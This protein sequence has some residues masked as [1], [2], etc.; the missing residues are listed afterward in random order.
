[1]SIRAILP[2][3]GAWKRLVVHAGES[4]SSG[5]H[6][7]RAGR[8]ASMRKSHR[9]DVAELADALGSGLSSRKGVEVQVLSSAPPPIPRYNLTPVNRVEI[10]ILF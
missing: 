5:V 8:C 3:D 2:V 7:C 1:M 10:L 9:A 6:F 4:D